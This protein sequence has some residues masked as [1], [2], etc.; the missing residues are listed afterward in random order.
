MA[1]INTYIFIAST[2]SQDLFDSKIPSLDNVTYDKTFMKPDSI[3]QMKIN[4]SGMIY[5]L[6]TTFS[7][8]PPLKTH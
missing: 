2:C 4:A 8:I 1:M 5:F 7:E 3:L 6:L